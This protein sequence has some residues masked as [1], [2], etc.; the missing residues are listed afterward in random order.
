MG[1]T[2]RGFLAVA[3]LWAQALE[4]A[5]AHDHLTVLT[6]G[7]SYTFRFLAKPE[8]Q[9]LRSLAALL[10]PADER[11]GGAAAAKVEEYIDFV[12]SH[13]PPDLQKRWREGLKS[14][15][16]LS[17]EQQDEMLS[18]ASRNEF[19]PRSR[20]EQFFVMLKGAVTEGFYTSQEG[21][22]RELGYQG[23]GFLREFPGCTHQSH[24]T[25]AGYKPRL[26]SR[27]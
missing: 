19:A 9:T 2:R 25:P 26:M 14:Y 5:Q 15:D 20:P 1:S 3:A 7:R 11:S 18:A 27:G 13:A 12:L 17:A 21:I 6:A 16:G 24:E 8:L 23:L 4:A 10:I 22:Q